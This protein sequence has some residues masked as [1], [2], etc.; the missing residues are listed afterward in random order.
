MSSMPVL[1]NHA[2][3]EA[4]W[5]GGEYELNMSF[6]TLRDVQWQ[7]LVETIW[8]YDELDGP[9]A[10]RYIPGEV[11]VPT[12]IHPP[13]QTATWVQYGRLLVEDQWVGCSVLATRSLFECVSMQ[14]P[15]GMFEGLVD[16]NGESVTV[17]IRLDALEH[18]YQNIALGVFNV[19]P[20]ELANIGYLSECQLVTELQFDTERRLQLLAHGNFFARDDIMQLLRI[21]P[22]D[23]PTVRDNLRWVSPRSR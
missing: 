12:D 1:A 22:T 13:E 4:F 14:V 9:F 2:D 5:Q 15:L 23:Y 20:F 10:D 17:N 19:V 11:G 8:A 18:V 21:N 7:G 3:P 6:G 16:E